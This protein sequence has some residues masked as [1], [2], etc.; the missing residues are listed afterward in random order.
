M[1]IIL[2]DV[3]GTLDVPGV[4]EWVLNQEHDRLVVWSSSPELC[5]AAAEKYGLIEAECMDKTQY[6]EIMPPDGAVEIV[7]VDDDFAIAASLRRY[8][9]MVADKR[10]IGLDFVHCDPTCLPG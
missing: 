8:F 5:S 1:K 9:M 2:V 4:A 7:V 3:K 6:N 10:D